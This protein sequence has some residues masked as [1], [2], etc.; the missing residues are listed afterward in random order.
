MPVIEQTRTWAAVEERL[1]TETDPTLRRNLELVLD[2]MKSEAAGD[3]DGLLV[4]LADDANYHAYGAPPESNPTGKAEVRRFY[5]DFIASGATRL[6]LDIDRL[7]VDKRCILT[8]GV[9]R[10]AYP[11]STL[12]ACGIPV[13]DESAYYLY[14]ARMATLWPF[15]EDGL[16]IGEDTYTGSNGFEGIASRK[17]APEDIV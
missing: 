10:I 12:A 7:V 4:T 14:E 13:D 6:Q 1:A 2:H 11:G 5:E 3:L 15:N 17:L 16:I 9:M 8:E